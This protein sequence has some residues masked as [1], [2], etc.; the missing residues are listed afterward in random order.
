MKITWIGHSCFKVEKDGFVILIDPYGDGSVPGLSPV[1]ESA[2]MVLCSHEHG[3]HNNRNAIKLQEAATTPFTIERINTYHDEV[4]GAKR[5]TNQIFIIDDGV[6]R[7]AHLGDLGCVPQ[8]E[9]LEELKGLDAMLIPVGGYYTIDA[10]QA[11]ELVRK[12]MPRIAVPM[13]YRDGET[14]YAEI[15]TVAEFTENMDS[16]MTIPA[17][18]IETTEK[19]GAQVVVLQPANRETG[20]TEE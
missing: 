12:T 6:N 5:G 9:Q 17:N 11:S 1:R 19:L 13:H 10:Q 14:G 20:H 3:D 7:I 15:G 16:V 4:S 8:A 18:G 2:N